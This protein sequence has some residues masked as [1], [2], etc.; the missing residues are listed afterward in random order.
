M[1]PIPEPIR[2]AAEAASDVDL[3]LCDDC[4]GEGCRG[5]LAG[6]HN[7]NSVP[8]DCSCLGIGSDVAAVTHFLLSVDEDWVE[9]A[10]ETIADAHTADEENECVE[11]GMSWPCVPVDVYLANAEAGVDGVMAG[12]HT[13]YDDGECYACSDRRR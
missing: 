13:P 10:L 2:L 7:D 9:E 11:C 12:E 1:Q 5:C 4:E 3:P 8:C 6:T